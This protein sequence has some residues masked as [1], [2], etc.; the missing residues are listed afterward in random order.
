MSEK[1]KLNIKID[2]KILK[3][4]IEILDEKFIWKELVIDISKNCV[5]KIFKTKKA[6]GVF[7]SSI[8]PINKKEN[9]YSKNIK[10]A[11]NNQ[12]FE[13]NLDEIYFY[14]YEWKNI[15]IETFLKI[16][17]KNKIITKEQFFYNL[18]SKKDN[19]DFENDVFVEDKFFLEKNFAMLPKTSKFKIIFIALFT[20]LLFIWAISFF[21]NK[22]HGLIMI[23]LSIP[24][25]YFAFLVI[26][27]LM[28]SYVN[29]IQ[30]NYV[31]KLYRWKKYYISDFFDV[32][33]AVNLENVT[34]KIVACNVEKWAYKKLQYD[35][36]R[37][38]SRYRTNFIKTNVR[39]IEFFN[40]NI[41]YISSWTNITS[42]I[43]EWI[44]FDKILEELFPKQIVKKY[45]W[46]DLR[47]EF[48]LVI[49]DFLDLKIPINFKDLEFN[50]FK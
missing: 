20:F 7:Y 29:V 46:I 24:F 31:P 27:K 16:K 41:D 3:W 28:L 48:Q 32:I 17:Y 39:Q 18:L 25:L 4:N 33:S 38:R 47:I 12:S 10:I 26:K 1:I 6:L 21:E 2:W 44:Y 49:K 30:K 36:S 42:L 9:I 34:L 22:V 11:S 15:N 19:S 35:Y 14:S 43:R 13:I 37:R 23:I 50:D 45:Y 40:E 5:T 8:I